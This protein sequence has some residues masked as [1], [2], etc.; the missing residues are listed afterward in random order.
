MHNSEVHN[1]KLKK[2]TVF[3]PGNQKFYW[4]PHV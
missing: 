2:N 3:F 1:E 4:K